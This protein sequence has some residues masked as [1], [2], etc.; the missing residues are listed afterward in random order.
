MG[1]EDSPEYLLAALVG[2]HIVPL[3]PREVV[4]DAIPDHD[5]AEFAALFFGEDTGC[6]REPTHRS[7]G[8]TYLTGGI[9]A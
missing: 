2:M 4:A 6:P 1:R 3:K 9:S 8:G 5:D 7:F